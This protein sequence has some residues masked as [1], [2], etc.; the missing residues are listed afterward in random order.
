MSDEFEEVNP[1]KGAA[2]QIGRR[3]HTAVPGYA[4]ILP[5][6]FPFRIRTSELSATQCIQAMLEN[7]YTGFALTSHP[8]TIDGHVH[9]WLSTEMADFLVRIDYISGGRLEK[10]E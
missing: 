10:T 2:Y 4:A 9:L 6:V 5:R 1:R 7:D 3:R 8:S